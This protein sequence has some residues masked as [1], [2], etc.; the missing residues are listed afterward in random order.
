MKKIV[1]VMDSAI[2]AM[3]IR[4]NLENEGYLVPF[5]KNTLM[6]V[7]DEAY[8]M[9]LM[10]LD[11]DFVSLDRIVQVKSPIIF[12]SSKKESEISSGEISGLSVTYDFL[13][14]PFTE[15]E[16]LIKTSQILSN[17]DENS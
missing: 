4:K 9:D 2:I 16:L 10:I 17:E 5:I 11:M 3:E 1:L 13:Y 8:D 6:S 15:K 12:L 7:L 14:K